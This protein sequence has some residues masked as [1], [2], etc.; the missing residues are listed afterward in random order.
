MSVK[1]SFSATEAREQDGLSVQWMDAFDL[2]NQIPFA[3]TEHNKLT[4]VKPKS[5]F[6][7]LGEK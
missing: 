1:G 7:S 3:V 6:F 5:K 4:N 2:D